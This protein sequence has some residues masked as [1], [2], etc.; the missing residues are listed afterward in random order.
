MGDIQTQ[1]KSEVESAKP[2]HIRVDIP[3][4]LLD[5]Y[6]RLLSLDFFRGFTMIM[7]MFEIVWSALGNQY[8]DGTF[9]EAVHIEFSHSAWEGL[10][11]WDLVQ[12]FFMFIVGVA[13]PISFGKRWD[14]GRTWTE[15]LK[16]AAKRSLILLI[17]GVAVYCIFP[18]GGPP[19]PDGALRLEF[20]DVLAQLAFTYFLAFLIMR[21]SW[22]FQL[23][24]TL[25]ILVLTAL[26]YRLWPVPGF[27]QP[28][29][30]D[31]NFGSWLDLQITGYVS[32]GHW[33]AAN[34]LPTACHTIWGVIAGQVLISRLRTGKKL[35]M[36]VIAG[37]I[38]LIL[39]YGLSPVTPVIKRIATVTFT[40]AS[41]GWCLLVLAF[42]FWLIDVKKYQIGTARFF[43]I[44]G[45]NAIFIYMFLQVG[46]TGWFE[47]MVHP[48]TNGFLGLLQ[49][50]APVIV[51]IT[52]IFVVAMMYYMLYFLYRK[53]I[54]IT[55]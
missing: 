28:F 2:G 3:R 51:V 37:L 7:L 13:M 45:M 6:G 47:R 20:W 49:I 43:A 5:D 29:T 21:R 18:T 15:T 23:I 40:L 14:R 44:P 1:T 9:L 38:G 35:R 30:P 17:L 39:G 12:P 11:F 24:F 22:N 31:H 4:Q 10:H 25:G 55:I 32:H 42:S 33:V 48:F 52:A 34:A 26:L 19:A 8:F 46:G 54:F 27:N 50:P 41:G 36:L 53:K 16:H